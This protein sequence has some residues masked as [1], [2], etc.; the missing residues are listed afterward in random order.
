MSALTAIQDEVLKLINRSDI[1]A[2]IKERL[3]L[4]ESI[5]RHGVDVRTED[6]KGRR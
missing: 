2:A 1:A 5:A 3:L 6:E 4:V